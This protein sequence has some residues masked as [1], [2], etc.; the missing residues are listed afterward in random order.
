MR[1]KALRANLWLGLAGLAG[2]SAFL[3]AGV[4]FVKTWFYSLAWWS[5]ILFMDGLNVR[6][7]GTSPL[8]Q[9]VRDFAA[10]A[11]LSVPAWLVF[12]MANLRLRNW[13]YHGLPSG[14]AERWLGYFVAFATVIPALRELGD[15]FSGLLERTLRAGPGLRVGPGARRALAVLGFAALGL[16]LLWPEAFFPLVWVG[17]VFLLDP[18]NEKLGGPSLLRDLAEGRWSR[19][20]GWMSAGLAAGILWELWNWGAG[21][22]WR[23]HIPWLDFG[24]IFQMPVLGYGGFVPFGLEIFALSAFLFAL[25]EKL[26]RRRGAVLAAAAFL[27]AFDLLAFRL[28]DLH[29]VH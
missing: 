16:P 21:A 13:S 19:L 3:A 7:R 1:E 8:S 10:A 4:P 2:A 24:R 20:A 17:F 11:F 29:S 25:R 18:A 23:Y 9:S 5:F 12:E 15:F 14:T 22:H 6:L 28:I 26:R 27:L